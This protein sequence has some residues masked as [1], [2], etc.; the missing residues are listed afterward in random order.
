M[1]YFPVPY[2]KG[3]FRYMI[4]AERVSMSVCIN[5]KICA[6]CRTLSSS[7]FHQVICSQEMQRDQW[8]LHSAAG[9]QG[10]FMCQ[11][12]WRISGMDLLPL[13]RVWDPME[14]AF[15]FPRRIPKEFS[16]FTTF[17]THYTEFYIAGEMPEPF[18]ALYSKENQI[19][20]LPRKNEFGFVK[21]IGRML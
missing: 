19:S 15:W 8:V 18:S 20:N 21:S 2:L 4:G 10:Y 3:N 12:S 9:E 13:V 5:V 14:W 6:Q 1:I 7:Q 11:S 17:L 16:P